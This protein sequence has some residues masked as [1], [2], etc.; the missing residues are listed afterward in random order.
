MSRIQKK[1]FILIAILGTNIMAAEYITLDENETLVSPL[2]LP[3]ER[4]E[5]GESEVRSFINKSEKGHQSIIIFGANWCPDC[6]ILE[7]TLKLPTIERYLDKYFSV[8]HVDVGDYDINMELLEVAGVKK[9]EGIP[10]IVIFGKGS[11]PLN[12]GVTD[13]MRTARDTKLQDIFNYFQNFRIE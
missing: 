13:K 7:A 3:Y 12:I 9:E 1:I 2:P 6:R 4:R 11:E 10:R 5:I 8:L